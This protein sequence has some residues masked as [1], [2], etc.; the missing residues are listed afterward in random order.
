VNNGNKKRII[1]N[2]HDP[3]KLGHSCVTMIFIQ[4]VAIMKIEANLQ[5]LSKFKLFS[6]TRKHEAGTNSNR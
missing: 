2:L 1:T 4:K 3:Y 5:K 6:E